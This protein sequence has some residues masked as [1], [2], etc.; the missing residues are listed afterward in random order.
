MHAFFSDDTQVN[1]GTAARTGPLQCTLRAMQIDS[2][3]IIL[4]KNVNF[5]Y[6]NLKFLHITNIHLNA[7]NWQKCQLLIKIFYSN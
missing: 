2:M 1:F 7:D 5:M 4:Y 6:R 3:C